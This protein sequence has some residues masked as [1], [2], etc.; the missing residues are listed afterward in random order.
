MRSLKSL[1][2]KIL[3]LEF[4]YPEVKL[5]VKKLAL[6]Y[7]VVNS[8]YPEIDIVM[9]T[10]NRLRETKR[11]INNL[12]KSTSVKFNLIIV[13]NN[14][15]D[16]TADYLMRLENEHSNIK[17][18]FS[19]QNLGGAGAR[20]IG[21]KEVK[22]KYVG[23]L[24]NDIY[25]MPGYFENLISTL[26]QYPI[27]A[28][29]QSKVISP[30]R[31]IQINR[32]FYEIEDNWIIFSD[33]DLEKEFNDESTFVSEETNWT[34]SGATLWRSDVFKD[35]IFDVQLG[36]YYEDNEFSFRLNK[37]GYTF[38][39]NHMALCLHYSSN[40]AP[41]DTDFYSKDRFNKEAIK[42]ALKNFYKKHGL[43]MAYGSIEGHT[44]FLG[45]KSRSEYLK[46][47]QET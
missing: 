16:E 5:E 15:K 21:I 34:P 44:K 9:P 14:S 37:K 31:K 6:S 32:P 3:D 47:I 28:A 12:Y 41:E 18:I 19:K 35:E 17:I 10:F 39:N 43:F 42:A 1:I 24:D 33:H 25:I 20:N 23:F 29:V 22:S 11:T 27:T 4:T 36:T 45:F 38:R 30:N 26:D 40:F 13:D 2:L 7:P 8:G 46:F